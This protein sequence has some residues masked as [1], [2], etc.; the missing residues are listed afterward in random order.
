[1]AFTPRISQRK[2]LSCTSCAKKKLRCSK[3]IPCT[4]CIDRGLEASCA[5]EKVIV[6]KK[7][8]R[9]SS[10]GEG[11][12]L[13]TATTSN[14][15]PVS[16]AS[17]VSGS[18]LTIDSLCDASSPEATKS[19]HPSAAVPDDAPVTLENLALG[20]QRILNM[21]FTGGNLL[22]EPD[23]PAWLPPQIDF[24]VSLAQARVLLAY[25]TRHLAWIHNVLHMPTFVEE[26]E[27]AFAQYVLKSRAWIA[28]FYAFL[29]HTAYHGPE[30]LL[31]AVDMLPQ[32]SIVEQ[33]YTKTIE[34][35]HAADFMAVHSL[36]AAQAISLLIQVGHN[37]GQSDFV[38]VLLS[39]TT[40]IA[41]S[42]DVNRLGPDS[43]PSKDPIGR[44]IKKRLWWFLV[45]Q[46][47]MQIPY[48]NMYTIN[49]S[50]FNTPPPLNCFEDPLH[51]CGENGIKALDSNVLTQSSWAGI[52]NQIAILIYKTHEKMSRHGPPGNDPRKIKILYDEVLSAN[53]ELQQL[54]HRRPDFFRMEAP[55]RP[56]WPSTVPHLRRLFAISFARSISCLAAARSSLRTFIEWPDDDESLVF[57]KMWTNNNNLVAAAVALLLGVLF[58]SEQA[59][60]IFEKMEMRQLLTDFLPCLGR[61]GA[62][63][64]VARRGV[65]LISIILDYERAIAEGTKDRLDIEEVVGHVKSSG[66]VG[67]APSYADWTN[68]ATQYDFMNMESWIDMPPPA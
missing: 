21:R 43:G 11:S 31:A 38:F 62:Y 1:M 67:I 54:W 32:R 3:S 24:I 6:R 45:K 4:S 34:A 61:I 57:K 15:G 37:L 25:H 14:N 28:L 44:E 55:L 27:N 13:G 30:S 65:D 36:H 60:G 39:T 50:H 52:H 63:S 29:C 23:D 47:W 2:P 58:S 48:G 49:A 68:A 18:P 7:H 56:E 9:S 42:L 17:E 12:S 51:M 22:N 8:Q 19:Q 41:Q 40:R 26:C 35:L 20:R 46:D 16:H 33:L 66:V 59:D 64:S 5:R 10:I 53:A